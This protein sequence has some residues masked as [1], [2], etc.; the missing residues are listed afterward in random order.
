MLTFIGSGHT[1]L[2]IVVWVTKDQDTELSFWFTAF[3]VAVIILGIT[4]I[5]VERARGYLTTPVLV[6]TA[7]FAGLGLAFKPV[8]GF[9]SLL[10]P[11]AVGVGSWIRRRSDVATAAT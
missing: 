4:A 10:V 5:E 1:A 11:I 3:G 2:G 6:A 7:A 8:S 9:L